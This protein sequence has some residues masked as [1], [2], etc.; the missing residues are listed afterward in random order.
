MVFHHKGSGGDIIYSLPTIRAFG[1]GTLFLRGHKYFN[2]FKSLFLKQDYIDEVKLEAPDVEVDFDFGQQEYINLNGFRK[3][4]RVKLDQH[5]AQTH[6]ETFGKYYD[7][8]R[9]WIHNV[10]PNKRAKIIINWTK[11]YHD[12]A[13]INWEVL[14]DYAQDCLFIGYRKEHRSFCSVTGIEMDFYECQDALEVAEIISGSN[15][16][17]GNQSLCFAIAESIKHPRAL[18][19]YYARNNCQPHGKDGYTILNNE[20]LDK[21]LD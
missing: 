13:E 2:L 18:E 4:E 15:F 6:L 8:N 9:P 20:I 7:L 10:F 14:K 5:L 12:R 11:R 1:G 17:I 19:V 21:Y 16:F 3:I